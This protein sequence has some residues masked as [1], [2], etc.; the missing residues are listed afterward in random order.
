[1][2]TTPLGKHP[3]TALSIGTGSA[4]V[5]IIW[6]LG[7]LG[8]SMPNE[9]AVLIAGGVTSLALLIG[10]KGVKGIGRLLWHGSD[11]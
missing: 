8:V 7:H 10:R 5:L 1:M 11:E 9:V 3:N 6:L 4:G 2:N